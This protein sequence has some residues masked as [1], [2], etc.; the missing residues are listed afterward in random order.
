MLD[1]LAGQ[2]ARAGT[3]VPGHWLLDAP[4]VIHIRVYSADSFV[5]DHLIPSDTLLERLRDD[6]FERV[7]LKLNAL[8][9]ADTSSVLSTPSCVVQP[10]SGS[11]GRELWVFS[12]DESDPLAGVDVSV[13]GTYF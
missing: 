2:P 8:N 11:S 10:A 1:F 12:A 3:P 5:P 9:D 13:T 6:P 7:W 4:A